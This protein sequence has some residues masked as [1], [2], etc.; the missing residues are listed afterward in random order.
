MKRGQQLALTRAA[1]AVVADWNLTD[2]L[3]NA[4]GWEALYPVFKLLSNDERI[5][6]RETANWFYARAINQFSVSVLQPKVSTD[7]YHRAVN[8]L[9][10]C[11]NNERYSDPSSV[12]L[13]FM[14]MNI[15]C[16]ID[17]PLLELDDNHTTSNWIPVLEAILPQLPGWTLDN[18]DSIAAYSS[19]LLAAATWLQLGGIEHR[20]ALL[21]AAQDA[22]AAVRVAGGFG[23]GALVGDSDAYWELHGLAWDP[24]QEVRLQAVNGLLNQDREVGVNFLLVELRRY[25]E[26]PSALKNV[27]HAVLALTE[28]TRD[29]EVWRAAKVPVF[30]LLHDL[31]QR[32]QL[33]HGHGFIHSLRSTATALADETLRTQLDGVLNDPT[34]AT[35]R[36]FLDASLKHLGLGSGPPIQPSSVR[37]GRPFTHCLACH[38]PLEDP[39]SRSIGYGPLCAQRLRLAPPRL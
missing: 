3:L 2:D 18:V 28:E 25:K 1:E 13:H 23:L 22:R 39:V 19:A 20:S 34:G 14:C 12:A 21:S 29:E 9:S 31:A 4:Y 38:R 30:R 37:T 27:F 35:Q 17:G 16:D 6:A 24:D 8:D 10:L 7:I 36:R 15:Y 33:P 32:G 5:R 26:D 11:L